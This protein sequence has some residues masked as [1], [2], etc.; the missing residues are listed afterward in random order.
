MD[1]FVIDK[2]NYLSLICAFSKHF[3]LIPIATRNTLDI[4][5]ALTT[6]FAIFRTP[7]TIVCD[8]EASF[9]SIQSKGFLSNLGVQL[10]FAS[11]LESNGQ[12]EKTHSTIIELFNTNKH[13]Y[14][15]LHSPEMLNIICSIY[16]ETIHSA[17]WFSRNEI[18][19]NQRNV[20]NPTE[21]AEASQKIFDNAIVHL[22]KAKNNM[23]K[24]KTVKN[25]PHQ[26]RSAKTFL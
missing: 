11:S 8:H 22:N 18:V 19:F 24:Y 26:S 13:K 25:I 15:E 20:V 10:E 7:E 12:I 2:N 1:I 6:Y 3:H 9:T 5:N 23:E 14:P 16:N 21:I 4:Q 17:T